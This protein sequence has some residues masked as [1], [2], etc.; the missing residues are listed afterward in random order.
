MS[1]KN[2]KNITDKSQKKK[3]TIPVMDIVET[4]NVVKPE[5]I[6]TKQKSEIVKPPPPPP[7]QEVIK[8]GKSSK[9]D[10]STKATAKEV[11]QSARRPP[12]SEELSTIQQQSDYADA[13]EQQPQSSSK[14]SPKTTSEETSTEQQ[15]QVPLK[16]KEPTAPPPLPQVTEIQLKPK[17]GGTTPA[18]GITTSE[19]ITKVEFESLNDEINELNSGINTLKHSYGSI[20][21]S[22][23]AMQNKRLM[24]KKFAKQQQQ[25]QQIDD[26][27]KINFLTTLSTMDSA[28]KEEITQTTTES[29]SSNNNKYNMENFL[30]PMT[31]ESTFQMLFNEVDD[32]NKRTEHLRTNFYDRRGNFLRT[33]YEQSDYHLDRKK[34]NHLK[35]WTKNLLSIVNELARNYNDDLLNMFRL[36]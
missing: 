7:Q 36:V 26:V 14:P 32:L 15:Q 6:S 29:S 16:E 21:K 9:K 25:Q 2:T 30:N 4:T 34:F 1:S 13:Y 17:K 28:Q 12:K 10:K 23:I 33:K 19:R 5:I 3:P 24:K 22:L 35:L 31:R 27:K 11:E 18:A 8:S 20:I